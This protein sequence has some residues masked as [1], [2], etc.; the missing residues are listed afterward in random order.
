MKIKICWK[1]EQ[2]K[3]SRRHQKNEVKELQNISLDLNI[4]TGSQNERG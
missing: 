3:L 2:E 1:L 4:K